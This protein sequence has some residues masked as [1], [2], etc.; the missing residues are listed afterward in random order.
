MQETFVCS[1][2]QLNYT[3]CCV[4]ACC[5]YV[6][7][8]GT[9]NVNSGYIQCKLTGYIQCKFNASNTQ[10]HT[11]MH[12]Y[13]THVGCCAQAVLV[14][15]FCCHGVF[16]RPLA[17]AATDVLRAARPVLRVH[18]ELGGLVSTPNS[19]PQFGVLWLHRY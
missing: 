15:W 13:T 19:A 16:Q 1:S 9:F 3:R 8:L 17:P 2:H 14:F 6:Y 18:Q 11:I 7:R 10:N 12:S 4:S 5:V